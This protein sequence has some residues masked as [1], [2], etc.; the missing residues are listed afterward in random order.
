MRDAD[1]IAV[2]HNGQVV[3]Q[4]THSELLSLEGAYYKLVNTQLTRV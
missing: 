1:S 3:E 2:I 4:G